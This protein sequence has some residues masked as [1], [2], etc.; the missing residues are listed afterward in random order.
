MCWV[1]VRAGGQVVEEFDAPA[2]L[3]KARL[4]A[5]SKFGPGV[6]KVMSYADHIE[7]R[8]EA[9]ALDRNARMRAEHGHAE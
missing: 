8:R 3:D 5:W 4:V 1:A 2:D 9:E 7:A 6:E